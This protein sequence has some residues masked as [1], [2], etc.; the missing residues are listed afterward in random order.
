MDYFVYTLLTI[1][2]SY[3]LICF[4]MFLKQ[5]SLLFLPQ[6]EMQHPSHHG[7]DMMEE[8]IIETSDGVNI[9]CWYTPP[10]VEDAPL[11]V[12]FHGNALHIGDEWRVNKFK[13]FIEHQMGVGLISYRGY[14]RSEGHASEDGLY[15][16]ARSTIN[17]L[18]EHK[19]HTLNQMILYGESLGTGVAMQMALEKPK[20]KALILEAPY[21][22]IERKGLERY[23]SLPV[24]ILIRDRFDSISKAP[25][26]KPKTLVIHGQQDQT[27]PVSH[28]H[29]ILDALGCKHKK[30]LF[31][32]EYDHTNFDPDY[33]SQSIIALLKQ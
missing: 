15:I 1:E 9:V 32:K 31:P 27:I 18:L 33:L 21:T 22:S 10:A 28:G 20:V 30:G 2:G 23:P 7:L 29:K 19:N 24:R 11:L 13:S 6:G 8:I 25:H 17:Y 12:Y 14:G 26:I 3:L 5:R 16:D 4:Y